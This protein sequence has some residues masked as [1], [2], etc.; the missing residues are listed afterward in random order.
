M[1]FAKATAFVLAMV[2][3]MLTAADAH[4]QVKY[5][6]PPHDHVADVYRNHVVFSFPKPYRKVEE[7][8]PAVLG[9]YAWRVSIEGKDGFSIV[10]ATTKPIK[11][12]D[13][14]EV[15]RS[16]TLRLCPTSTSAIA[17][18]TRVIKGKG[19][20]NPASIKLELHEPELVDRI[21]KIRPEAYWRTAIEPGGRYFVDQLLLD[22]KTWL[23]R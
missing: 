3:T 13:Y 14:E 12:N 21:W 5:L 19:K 6:G 18:C 2:T 15:M 1:M 20:I 10:L 7:P 22:Y 9:H 16:A 4:A 17:D 11:T 23:G 8:K